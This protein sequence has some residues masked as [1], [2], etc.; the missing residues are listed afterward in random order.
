MKGLVVYDLDG[1][2]VDSSRD[3]ATAVNR[4]LA[5]LGGATLEL[6]IVRSFIGEGARALVARATAAAGLPNP[7]EEVLPRFFGEYE[8]CLL[9]TTRLYE[10]IEDA[11]RA[12]PRAARAVLTNKPGHFSRR[13]LEGLGADPWFFRV[14]GGG[15]A[16]EKKPHPAG[17]L[18]LM[19]EAGAGL[20]TTVMV[21]DSAIDVRTGRAAGVRTV[22]VRYG[23]DPGSLDAH[24][25][26][27]LV[28]DPA[29]L[30]EALP[31]LLP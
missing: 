24:P 18:A 14:V 7:P 21:G 16:P 28:D 27:L 11:L 10:G 20:E 30:A 2:L 5:A 15:D 4:T 23:Y 17:L 26:D 19:A 3:L 8:R 6:D 22:A 9:D 29:G 1:T 12:T 25:P 31:K 13:I